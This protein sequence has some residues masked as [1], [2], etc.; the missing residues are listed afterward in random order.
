MI[1]RVAVCLVVVVLLGAIPAGVAG[2]SATAPTPETTATQHT[3]DAGIN[4]GESAAT[5]TVN[6]DATRLASTSDVLERTTTLR[7]LP[8][9]P[10]TFETAMTFDVPEPMTG[11]EIDLESE[12]EVHTAEGF[13]ATDRGTYRWDE[14]TESP[15]VRF[16]MPANRTGTVDGHTSQ[17]VAE[18]AAMAP[19]SDG[20]HGYTFLETGEWGVVRVPTV[21]LSYR[22]A[23]SDPIGIEETVTVDGPG[24][25]GTELAVFGEVTEHERTV[26]GERIR[27][28]VLEAADLR[29]RPTE[30]LDSLEAASERLD[31]GS[32][33]TEAVI[34]AVPTD[35]DWGSRGLQ[36]GP[37]DA[38]VVA[39]APLA[40]ATNVWLHEYVHIR[41]R[42]ANPGVGTASDSEWLIEAQAEYYA[43][44]LAY[45]QELIPFREF[46]RLLERG[47][48]SPAA[49][50]VLVEPSTWGDSNANY[51]KGA[52]VYGDLDR[53]LRLATDGD[54]SLDDVFRSLNAK[55]G[56]IRE[57][58]VL[59]ALERAGNPAIR[60]RA[61]RYTRTTETPEPWTRFE[62]RD[63]FD[64]PR[65]TIEYGLGTDPIR[66]DDHPWERWDRTDIDG[67]DDRWRPDSGTDR[68]VL[69]VPAGERVTVPVAASNVGE[70]A[71]TADVVLQAGGEIVAESQHHL[72]S[73]EHASE[74]LSWTPTDPGIYDVLVGDDR[75]TVVVRSTTSLTVTDLR[76]SPERI[77]PGESVTATATVTAGDDR[78]A[79][80]TLEFQTAAETV[81][82]QPIALA[83][84]ET[85]TVEVDL[86]FNEDGRYE[87]V[88]GGQSTTV[89]VGGVLGSIESMPG[90]GGIAGVVALAVALA[91]VLVGRRR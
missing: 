31:V 39:D 44:L 14:T 88:A 7:Q 3:L 32:S 37:S 47:T 2:G 46:S 59:E 28:V 84:G 43:G 48:A 29:E 66:V 27:L 75:L 15:T 51:R 12:A 67:I 53:Q 45:E 57:A 19:T 5:P 34:V 54:R 60:E 69:A 41:Q 17:P 22:T 87:I 62:H 85:G 49:D 82:G 73:G 77:D 68:G 80:G 90:F 52:L 4:G 83:P 16:T 74:T 24:T 10:G 91:V 40:E 33:T 23:T 71:G 55:D 30:I 6:R 61:E 9:Q 1:T 50:A 11:L 20:E 65:A 78:P 76:V 42:F 86:Q 38:W 35:V 81:S 26:D 72:E 63:A 25:A 13:E 8:A 89:T 64:Q 70:R 58:D 56:Q 21:G 36:Y 18:T 79:A